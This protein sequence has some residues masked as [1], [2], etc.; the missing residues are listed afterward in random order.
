MNERAKL[1]AAAEAMAV[2]LVLIY[3][4]GSLP[5]WLPP[6]GAK[7]LYIDWM[8]GTGVYALLCISALAAGVINSL[9]GGGTLLTFSA[10]L[11]IVNPV[12]ANATSTVALVPGS[13][14]AAWGYRRE[15]GT[16][17]RWLKLLIWPSLLGG[18]VGTLLVTRLD[19]EYFKALVPWLILTAAILFL[20]QPAI[21]R[22]AGVGKSHAPPS[23]SMLAGL[24][25]FQFIVAVYGGYFGAGIGILMLS[26]LALM[27]LGDIHRANAVKT[28]L[29]SCINVVAVAIFVVERKVEWHLALGMAAAAI[30]GGYI[31]ARAA[32][33]MNRN[34]VRW[35]VIVIG[36]GLAAYYIYE[37]LKSR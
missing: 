18:G 17:G 8:S 23:N 2:V 13:M 34:L 7:S 35:I 15:I 14:A 29:A 24:V 1:V 5:F 31:G 26:S 10:L 30:I 4:V 21:G 9:A 32:R 12:A 19:E 22:F 25:V 11:T 27:G 16:S 37:Q 20:V 36:F 28:L 3:L 6:A 33:R